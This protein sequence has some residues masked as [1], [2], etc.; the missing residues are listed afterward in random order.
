MNC[1]S[2]CIV[3][4]VELM[5]RRNLLVKGE[6]AA[7]HTK[8]RTRSSHMSDTFCSHNVSFVSSVFEL[9]LL[10]LLELPS[11]MSVLDE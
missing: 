5:S 9:P 7:A 11:V 1:K 2:L 6:A 4:V 8:R 10:Q 3:K